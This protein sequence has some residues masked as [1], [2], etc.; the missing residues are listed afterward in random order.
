MSVFTPFKF[1]YD[2]YRDCAPTRKT[3]GVSYR[4]QCADARHLFKLNRLEPYEYN[5]NHLSDPK[6]TLADKERF[7]SYNQACIL[8]SQLNPMPSRGILQK[9]AFSQFMGTFGIPTP[10]SYGL[11]DPDFGYTPDCK[12]FRSV[13]DLKRVLDEHNLREFVIKPAGGAKGR[14]VTVISSRQGDRFFSG[15]ET[16]YSYEGLYQL[17]VQ[18]FQ[19]GLPHQRE[20]ILLQERI[21]QHPAL[22]QINPSCT[23]TIRVMTFVNQAG[24]IEI[25]GRIIKFGLGNTMVDNVDKGAMMANIDADGT[26]G[27]LVKYSPSKL[28]F[29]DRHPDTGAQIAGV[30]LPHFA[31]AIALA[32][33]A[34]LRLPQL[35]SLGFDIAITPQGPVIIEGNAWWG[36]LPQTITRQGFITE[37][38][39]EVLNRIM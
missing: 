10:R 27:P 5:D 32:R 37:G 34:Q 33:E 18:G 30:K 6:L 9:F 24:E 3:Y 22:D 29:I 19:T 17:M 2:L 12:S 39:R 38:M 4:F 21:K 11:F 23:N 15:S 16:V 8:N 20:C 1:R 7:L 25:I 28:E 31:E 36:I 14:G 26:I 35:R 13:E